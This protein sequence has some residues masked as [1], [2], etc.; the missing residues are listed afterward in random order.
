MKNY[1]AKLIDSRS[2]H[3]GYQL[4]GCRDPREAT[5]ENTHTGQV[6]VSDQLRPPELIMWYQRLRPLFHATENRD[7][8]T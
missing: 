8:K 4:I 3:S 7:V 1:W 5:N 6:A 2:N